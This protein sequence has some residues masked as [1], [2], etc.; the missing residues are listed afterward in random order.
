MTFSRGRSLV[1]VWID[2][3]LGVDDHLL[4]CGLVALDYLVGAS[5]VSCLLDHGVSATHLGSAVTAGYLAAG[6]R[7]PVELFLNLW[8]GYV[9]SQGRV[10]IISRV[11]SIRVD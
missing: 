8:F 1:A 3:L 5:C 10:I 6:S 2:R 11:S 9:L 7:G 4:E